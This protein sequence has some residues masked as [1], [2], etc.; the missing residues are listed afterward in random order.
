MVIAQILEIEINLEKRRYQYLSD[1]YLLYK[2]FREDN[3]RL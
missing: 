3:E 1:F 2:L